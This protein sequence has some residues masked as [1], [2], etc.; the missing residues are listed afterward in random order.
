MIP[1]YEVFRTVKPI[2]RESRMLVPRDRELFLNEYRIL[3]LQNNRSSG[4][5]SSNNVNIVKTF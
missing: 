5:W 3:V 2:E 4:N 1:R